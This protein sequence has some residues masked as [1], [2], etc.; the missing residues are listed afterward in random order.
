VFNKKSIP[1]KW[2]KCTDKQDKE[3]R[4]ELNNSA[5]IKY[6]TPINLES[7]IKSA[8]QFNEF[9]EVDEK[10]SFFNISALIH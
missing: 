3:M 6:S 1:P 4:I 5:K 7:I 8:V 2:I 9:L 10:K